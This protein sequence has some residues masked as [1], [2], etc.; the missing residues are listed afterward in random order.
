MPR[1]KFWRRGLKNKKG[2]SHPS[3]HGL[4]SDVDVGTPPIQKKEHCD[5][6]VGTPPIQKKVRND[7]LCTLP[8]QK[9][10]LTSLRARNS[11]TSL[12]VQNSHNSLRAQNSQNSLRAQKS[13]NESLRVQSTRS[14]SLRA[15]KS[16]NDTLGAQNSHNDTLQAHG[17]ITEECN[18]DFF[19]A[20]HN[21]SDDRY[22]SFSRGSQCTCM[23]LSMAISLFQNIAFSSQNL[24]RI[25]FL[26]DNLY[27]KVVLDLQN[28]GQFRNKLL[29]FDELPSVLEYDNSHYVI[30]KHTTIFGLPIIESQNSEVLSLHEGLIFGLTVCDYILVMMGSIC[31]CVARKGS[32]Y[33]FFDS[34]SHG[35]DGLSSADGR[36]CL[37]AFS[38]LD[39]LVSYMYSFYTS[40]NIDFSS[41]FE[42]LPIDIGSLSH[43][44]PDANPNLRTQRS[45]N[46]SKTDQPFDKKAYMKDY[47]RKRREEQHYRQIERKSE[48]AS[49]QKA[50]MN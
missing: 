50:R 10:V 37:I 19:F 25:L 28:E 33:I 26:G 42:V 13:H 5:I 6:D 2:I 22:S 45:V 46:A 12:R 30:S 17:C 16:Y 35:C 41:Q 4:T 7:D 11:H 29:L 49:K 14:D 8:I 21:Q 36:A 43:N 34:H 9:K 1:K 47:M 32:K 23:S 48:L 38:S 40:C 44:F 27:K 15:R 18:N 39:E 3:N 31:S 20:S 24:D